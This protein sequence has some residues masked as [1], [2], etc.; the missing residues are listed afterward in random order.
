MV[1]L[2]LVAFEMFVLSDVVFGLVVCCYTL[3]WG[4]ARCMCCWLLCLLLAFVCLF[5]FGLLVSVFVMFGLVGCL[6]CYRWFVLG[7]WVFLM[8]CWSL[9]CF[10]WF[11]LS[12]VGIGAECFRL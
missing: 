10:T 9:W 5:G 11:V 1:V 6:W 12:F 4:V 2:C 7:C 8:G 3:V